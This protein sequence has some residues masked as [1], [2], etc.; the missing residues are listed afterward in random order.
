V[1]AKAQANLLQAKGKLARAKLIEAET[2]K[3]PALREAVRTE[4]LNAIQ[5]ILQK[6][7]I[8]NDPKIQNAIKGGNVSQL[9]GELGEAIQRTQ[10][11]AKY[12][13]S[14]GYSVLSNVEVVQ[15]VPGFDSI[16]KWQAAEKA[17]GRTGDPGGLYE[18]GGQ[19]WKSLGNADSLVAKAGNGGKLQPVEIEEV[20]TGENDS[21][22]KASRQVAKVTTGLGQIAAGQK[23]IRIFDRVGKNEIG[24]DLTDKFDLSEITQVK[25]STRG[26]EG[27]GFAQSLGFDTA[28]L[29][30]LAESLIKNLPPANLPTIPPLVS[31]REKKEEEKE[32]DKEE[33]V[34]A[35]R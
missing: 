17:A 35:G 22:T 12:P 27:R 7:G 18:K 8:L 13:A 11:R 1:R 24:T 28:T 20:K 15:Q 34:P 23:G 19:L 29:N 6:A 10:M 9:V 26:P 31:P 21:P 33:L 30:L 32:Q 5:E 2:I 14:Q 16:A 25:T 3:D 4:Q